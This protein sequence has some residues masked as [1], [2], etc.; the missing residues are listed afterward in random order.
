MELQE[1]MIIY[2]ENLYYTQKFQKKAYD[3]VV[4][5]K[6]YIFGNKVWLN[7]RYIKTK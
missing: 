4:K 7:N 2:R 1:L 3:K 5:P 6:S